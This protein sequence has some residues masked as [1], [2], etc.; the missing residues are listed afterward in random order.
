[1]EPSGFDYV[2]RQ[3]PLYR[4]LLLAVPESVKDGTYD[5]H[6]SRDQPVSVSGKEG[7]LFLTRRGTVSRAAEEG[8]VTTAQQLRELFLQACG[9]SVFRHEEEI[10]QGYVRLG[11]NCRVGICGSAVVA[12][13]N[14]RSV[15]DVTSLVYRVPRQVTGCGDRLFLEGVPVEKGLLVV[16]PPSSG[17]TTLLRDVARSLSMGKFGA[18]CR[19]AVVDERGEL[20]GFDLGPN[21]DLLQGYPKAAGLD[22]AIRALSP[23]VIVLDEL[24]PRDLEAVRRAAAAGAALVAS[25]HGEAGKLWER[26]LCRS[27]LETGA[28]PTAVCLA[29]RYAPGEPVSIVAVTPEGGEGTFEAAGRRADYPQRA[30]G[31]DAGGH[32]AAAPGPSAA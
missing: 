6:I 28:F 16:G 9:Y 19:V 24:A 5:I 30:V 29:G 32:E 8:I 20:G 7:V 4:E 23:Q 3:I 14:V 11:E 12:G 26:P 25:V 2:A 17:K 15:R 18:S 22:A 13:G 10:R 27:L 1:M 21:A 31:R